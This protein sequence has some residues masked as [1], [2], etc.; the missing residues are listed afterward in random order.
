M[1]LLKVEMKGSLC[2]ERVGTNYQIDA[3][4][5]DALKYL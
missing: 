1:K 4:V 5:S 3:L 2:F